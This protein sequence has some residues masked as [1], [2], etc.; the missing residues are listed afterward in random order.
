MTRLVGAREAVLAAFVAAAVLIAATSAVIP[1]LRSLETASLD[2]RFRVRGVQPAG[3]DVSIILIDDK[4]LATFGRWPFSRH[5]LAQA[6]RNL[7]RA[8]AKLIVVDL[9]MAEPAPSV[10]ATLRAIPSHIGSDDPDGDLA[11]AI[12]QSGHVLLPFAFGF[13]GAPN[14]A[15]DLLVP[16]AYARFDRSPISPLF[17]MTPISATIP[18]SPM[19]GAALGLGH[20]NIAYDLDGAPRYDYLAL[21]FGG[22]FFPSMAMRA[23]A[24]YR[25]V[26]WQQVGLGLGQGV[27]IGNLTVPGDRGMRLLIN[28]LGPRGT[29]PTH[30]FADFMHGRVAASALAG[31]IVLIGASFTG[32]SDGNAS[33]FGNTQVT[34]VERLATAIDTIL[35]QRFILENPWPW[36]FLVPLAVLC[37]AGLGGIAASRLPT[38]LASLAGLAPLLI[39]TVATQFAFRHGLW[40]PLINPLMALALAQLATFL[41]RYWVTDRDARFIKSAFRHYL[42][43]ELVNALAA[44]PG[45]LRL[46]GETRS[47]TMM[48][49]DIRGFTTISERLQAD[50]QGLTRLINRFLTPM[51]AA[52]LAHRGTIDKYIGDCI[53]AFWNAPV[54][55]A[56]HAQHACQSA[57]A[58]LAALAEL[59]RQLEAETFQPLKVGIGLNSGNCVVGN[60][61]SDQ[62]FDYSVLGDAV[63]LASR[64]EG[65]SKLYGVGILAGDATRK[66][67]QDFAFLEVDRIVVVGKN[68]PAR[69]HALLGDPDEAR[70]PAFQNIVADHDEM[71]ARYRAQNWDAAKMLLARCRA[72][73][74]RLAPLYELYA[75]RIAWYENHPPGEAWDGVFVA[76]SK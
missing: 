17:P 70:S 10:P 12:Q 9:L 66:L 25:G 22:E 39:W 19:A 44:N 15:S 2:L 20:V 65:L 40:L 36:P 23:A 76:T 47:M 31:R 51:T 8:G 26:K 71:L 58:M 75:Q 53:M 72:R 63:N 62:R 30:S 5:L 18:A 54:D 29:V 38:W 35:G 34:G 14:Q 48:F 55:D 73:D 42:A 50:P 49:C 21:P 13:T 37:L 59:N 57:L 43:P 1:E 3:P 4:S 74:D 27:S 52:I 56:D 28:Y 11:A 7:D 69:V 46:G 41:F 6:I 60:M 32:A 68:E 64:L 16:S 61:G 24:E 67:A 33:P 45:R